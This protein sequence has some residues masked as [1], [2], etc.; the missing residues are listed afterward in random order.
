MSTKQRQPNKDSKRKAADVLVDDKIGEQAADEASSPLE[1]SPSKKKQKSSQHTSRSITQGALK[2]CQEVDDEEDDGD[3]ESDHEG[4]FGTFTMEAILFLHSY[5]RL[6]DNRGLAKLKKRIQSHALLVSLSTFLDNV[7]Q[8]RSRW[9]VYFRLLLQFKQREGH[10]RVPTQHVEDGLKLGAWIRRQRT[11]KKSEMLVPE[12][13]RR[14]N[15]IG[16]IWKGN[17]GNWDTMFRALT[18]FKQREGHLRV[19]TKHVEDG[20]KLGCWNET[21][22]VMKKAGTLV[23]G[24]ERRLNEIG[25]IWNVLD[26]SWDNMFRALMRFKQREGHLRVPMLHVEDGLKLGCW[27]EWQKGKKKSGTLVPERERRL[28]E[29]GFIWKDNHGFISKGNHRN[30]DTMFRALTQFKQREEHLDV[31]TRHVEDGLN[32]GCWITRQLQKKRAG[33][34]GPERERRLNEIGCIWNALDGFWDSMFRGLIRFKLRE[35]HL[36][37]PTEHV[38]D[39]LK[40]GCWNEAQKVMKKA[41]TLVHERE[42]RL[43]EIGYIWNALDEFWEKMIRA[44]AQ[45]KQR[46]GHLRVP[47]LH[48]EDGLKLGSWITRQQ[49]KRKV[50]T[51]VPERERRLNAIGY[52]WKKEREGNWDNMFRALA[53]FK[54]REG[55]LRVPTKHVEDGLKLGCWYETQKVRKKAGTLVPE[56][57]RRLNEIEIVEPE[58]PVAPS[59]SKHQRQPNKVSKRKAA[60]VHADDKTGEQVAEAASS[61]KCSPSKKKQKSSQHASRSITRGA[62]KS[63]QGEDGEEDDGDQESDHE[64]LVG[65]FTIGHTI[66]AC[67]FSIAG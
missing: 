10:L 15:E 39:G 29:I 31:P 64:G 22:K 28:N 49:R 33:T 51:L 41:G 4:H 67:V 63:C 60:D 61:P 30:W 53:Q 5:F 35:G 13:E 52:I 56:M 12:M 32:L 57:E 21:Q 42:R 50:G 25:C 62:L 24:R 36:R 66:L 20:L 11:H 8:K 59:M 26:G 47:M 37:V 48:V 45:F 55:H 38:E 9:D 44:L 27:N 18:Q 7:Y 19:P 17:H 34:L 3:Q 16:F 43:N 65:T 6:L 23:S 58:P 46:E 1:C 14:L 54:H 40:L 2:S